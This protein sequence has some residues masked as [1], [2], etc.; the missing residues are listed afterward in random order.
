M[1]YITITSI[2]GLRTV[3]YVS[4][5]STETLKDVVWAIFG[6]QRLT[7][8]Y[9]R[10]PISFKHGDDYK[11]ITLKLFSKR[12]SSLQKYCIYLDPKKTHVFLL[13]YKF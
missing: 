6:T 11:T 7:D 2:L 3:L 10:C 1:I 8:A 4:I 12:N 13:Y 5:L 9:V